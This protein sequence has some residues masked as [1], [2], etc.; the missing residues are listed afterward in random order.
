MN[1]AAIVAAAAAAAARRR[2]EEADGAVRGAG[3]SRSRIAFRLALG[4]SFALTLGAAIFLAL[5]GR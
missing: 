3:F 2:R 4:I 1:A 5:H